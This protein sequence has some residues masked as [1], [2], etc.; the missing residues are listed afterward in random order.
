M[1]QTQLAPQRYEG[2]QEPKDRIKGTKYTF[3]AAWSDRKRA[4]I[5]GFL[6]PPT[7]TITVLHCASRGARV[8]A[9]WEMAYLQ[10]SRDENVHHNQHIG[11]DLG[12]FCVPVVGW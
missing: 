8:W 11:A 12:G 1:P 3:C 2:K 6:L 9:V 10:G 5:F 7:A 4:K